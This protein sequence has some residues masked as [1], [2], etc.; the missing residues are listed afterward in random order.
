LRGRDVRLPIA[1]RSAIMTAT[2]AGE[3]DLR[4][5]RNST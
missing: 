3:G 1:G 4:D 5:L 2:I